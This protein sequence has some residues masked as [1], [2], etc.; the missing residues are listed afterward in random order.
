MAFS[1]VIFNNTTL[2]DVTSDTVVAD[3]LALNYTAHNAAGVSIT[4]TA[5]V[6]HTVSSIPSTKDTNIIKLSTNNKYYAWR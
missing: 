3:E 5:D 6:V 2:M 1:K 4:G